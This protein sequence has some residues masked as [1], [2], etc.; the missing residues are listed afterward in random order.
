VLGLLIACQP[1][2]AAQSGSVPRPP[3]IVCD[4]PEIRVSGVEA[5]T[6]N[7]LIVLTSTGA[8]DFTEL[9]LACT[10]LRIVDG[11]D[12]R[13]AP[14]VTTGPPK[15]SLKSGQPSEILLGFDLK[16][17]DHGEFRGKVQILQQDRI[18]KE[19]PLTIRVRHGW[20][21][22]LAVLICGVLLGVG[23]TWY[24]SQGQPLDEVISG[25]DELAVVVD[26][27][28]TP[29]PFRDAIKLRIVDI[30]EAIRTQDWAK[31]RQLVAEGQAIV[32]RWSRRQGEWE[33]LFAY[34]QVLQ[35]ELKRYPA[36]AKTIDSVSE[37]LREACQKAPNLDFPEPLRVSLRTYRSQVERYGQVLDR[38][39]QFDAVRRTAPAGL[40]AASN[41][42]LEQLRQRLD[43]TEPTDSTGFQAIETEIDA[44]IDALVK[45][46]PQPEA[47]GSV[48]G[49]QG[50]AAGEAPGH[51]P[52]MS[53]SSVTAALAAVPAAPTPPRPWSPVNWLPHADFG[54]L[55]DLRLVLFR[56]FGYAFPVAVFV[57]TGMVQF[58]QGK[59]TFGSVDNYIALFLWGF[60]ADASGTKVQDLIR[61]ASGRPNRQGVATTGRPSGVP[62]GTAG[63]Q[64][65]ARVG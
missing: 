65:E 41:E 28:T 52:S 64:P 51:I 57:Y 1:T 39:N 26:D 4:P 12:A 21:M 62:D 55:S 32:L 23:I 10:P 17:L 46:M 37:A 45:A 19:V 29:A 2:A 54:W 7:R 44:A 49:P 30:R 3:D 6:V 53:A 18:V 59:E 63:G 42:K 43:Q 13:P 34:I 24:R 33:D 9:T 47:P 61:D 35:S 22:P 5:T 27:P 8:Q 40:V 25:R 36:S 31:G 16:G 15:I 20:I 38:L 50:G 58:Y 11:D 60:G 56:W 14:P 48:P